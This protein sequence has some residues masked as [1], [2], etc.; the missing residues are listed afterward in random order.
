MKIFRLSLFN[1]K[2]NKKEAVAIMLLTLVST[3]M[4]GLFFANTSRINSAFDISF[5]E[6]GSKNTIFYLEE[7]EYRDAYRDVLVENYKVDNLEEIRIEYAFGIDVIRNDE[8]I[9]YGLWFITEENDKK[10]EDYEMLESLSDSEIEGLEHPIWLPGYCKYNL[11]YEL[12]EAFTLETLGK[13]YP[14][15]IAGFYNSGFMNDTE[16][17]C[18]VTKKDYKKLAEITDTHVLL[19]FDSDSDYDFQDYIDKCR[20]ESGEDIKSVIGETKEVCKADD[21]QFLMM[22]LYLGVS[23]SLITFIASIFMIRNKISNDIEDQMQQIGVLEALGYKSGEISLSYVGEY[24]ISA[25]IGTLIGGVLAAIITPLAN[26]AIS[27]M[28][29]RKVTSSGDLIL[30]IPVGLFILSVI[31]LFALAKAGKVKKYPPVIAFRKGIKTH[32]FKKNILPLA[33]LKGNVNVRI[34][35]KESL[36]NIKTQLGVGICIVLSGILLIFGV[37]N[38]DFFKVGVQAFSSITGMEEPDLIITLNSGVDAYE[39]RDEMLEM[40]EVRKSLVTYEWLYYNIKGSDYDASAIAYDDFSETENIFLSEGRYPV[41]D[42]EAMISIQRSKR[43]SLGIDDIIVV[44][45]NGIEE[46]YIITGVVGN[47]GNGC[48]CIYLTSDGYRKIN[49][50]SNQDVVNVY[51]SDGVDVEEFSSMLTSKFGQS[52]DSEFGETGDT[53][54]DH[55]SDAAKEKI[56]TLISKYGVTD[57]DWAVQ[58]GD[59]VYTGNSRQFVIKSILNFKYLNESQAGQIARISKVVSLVIVIA[60]ILIV[61]LILGIIAAS[62]VKRRSRELGIMK[63]L[64][65]SSKNLMTQAAAG[66]IPVTMVSVSI[67]CYLGSLI[68]KLFWLYIWGADMHTSL[69]VVII[70]GIMMV[71]FCYIVTY[72]GAGKIRK[73]SVTELITE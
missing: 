47:F 25:G 44:K 13:Q 32:N 64:G 68:N 37:L 24:M 38:Y 3:M 9:S 42:N 69:P 54:E 43:E 52:V 58:I 6:S 39:F 29:G 8:K 7:K 49:G 16:P 59:K 4:L 40:P 61:A 56:A 33:N 23:V 36:R 28:L 62:N 45:S 63:G 46:S 30:I 11:G 22:F 73:I 5:E 60:A 17:K 31:L 21:S 65:Y 51:L 71:V 20:A 35:F 12:G 66:I 50:G 48:N 2:K 72:I 1:L 14:F 57:L 34:A 53:L 55:L 41:H 19:A 10:L 18:V 70:S 26:T 27:V 67:S 15:I